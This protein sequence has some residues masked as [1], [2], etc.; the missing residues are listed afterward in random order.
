MQIIVKEKEYKLEDLIITGN[1]ADEREVN[2][3]I[4]KTD[5]TMSIYTSDNVYLTK[6]K[7]LIKSNPNKW[8]I[9]NIVH[10]KD[11]TVSGVMAEAPKKALSFR[12][13][14]DNNGKELSEEQK[15]ARRE[16]LQ[17]VRRRKV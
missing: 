3:N 17:A 14:A 13:T 1:P 7:N 6:I 12:A 16:I 5:E 15:E 8:R 10:R 2:I 11:G 4:L 9:T